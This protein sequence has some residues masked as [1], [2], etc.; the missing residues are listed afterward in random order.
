MTYNGET[1]MFTPDEQH[2]I[3]QANAIFATKIKTCDAFT[4]P[5]VVKGFCQTRIA[6][7]E[8]EIF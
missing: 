2:I 5:D 1:L 3:D 4:S 6:T 7:S 8:R